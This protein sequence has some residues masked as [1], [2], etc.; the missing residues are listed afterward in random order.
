MNKY[1]ETL[2][3]LHSLHSPFIEQVFYTKSYLLKAAVFIDM[4][5]YAGAV[6]K[7]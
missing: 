7:L 2:S 6:R 4:C 3:V 5:D 1:N